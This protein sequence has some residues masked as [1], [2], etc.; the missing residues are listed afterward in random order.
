MTNPYLDSKLAMLSVGTTAVTVP[1]TERVTGG[2]ADRDHTVESAQRT[3]REA[4]QQEPPTAAGRARSWCHRLLTIAAHN[5][6]H[7]L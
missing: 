4:S 5:P 6:P 3:I 2:I 7:L 1:W